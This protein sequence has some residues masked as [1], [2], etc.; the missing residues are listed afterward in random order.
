ME[1]F[2]SVVVAEVVVALD[3]HT[4]LTE[5]AVESESESEVLVSIEDEVL[6]NTVN[7]ALAQAEAV[8]T[9]QAVGRFVSVIVGQVADTAADI[10]VEQVDTR[11]LKFELVA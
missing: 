11:V 3:L 4:G 7:I 9:V 2:A 8:D 6:V 10:V 1:L 5:V